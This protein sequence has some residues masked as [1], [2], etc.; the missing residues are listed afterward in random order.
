MLKRVTTFLAR[1]APRLFRRRRYSGLRVVQRV[2]EVPDNT[3][4][5]IY[6]VQRNDTLLWAIFDCP[7]RTGHRLSVTLRAGDHPHW[8][9]RQEGNLATMYPSLWYHDHCHSHFWITR[10]QVRW[11]F[12]T[13]KV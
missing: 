4:S 10:N 11:L 13:S 8:T 1:R 2:S 5:V 7:C 3:G 12:D 6:L 9:L